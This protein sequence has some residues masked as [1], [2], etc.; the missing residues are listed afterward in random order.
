MTTRWSAEQESDSLA[1]HTSRLPLTVSD[2]QTPF[3]TT[4]FS[5]GCCDCYVSCSATRIEWLS[6]SYNESDR[7]EAI[8]GGKAWEMK[9]NETKERR[10]W[11]VGCC[12]TVNC[13]I[14]MRKKPE[15]A[16]IF[17]P[18]REEKWLLLFLGL[19]ERKY[20]LTFCW[21]FVWWDYE[22]E[23]AF[24]LHIIIVGSSTLY[25]ILQMFTLPNLTRKLFFKLFY[26]VT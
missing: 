15:S 6:E 11:T 10:V 9:R 13:E 8:D 24:G 3:S 22:N 21:G 1:L 18:K 25:I 5:M 12:E 2:E 4:P 19:N 17:R 20:E 7:I 23:I 26:L 14:K 16:G